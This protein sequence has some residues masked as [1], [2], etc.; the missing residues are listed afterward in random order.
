MTTNIPAICAVSSFRFTF[1]ACIGYVS[2]T[3]CKGNVHD[4]KLRSEGRA[5]ST[6]NMVVKKVLSV[7]FE[8][9]RKMGY[10]PTNPVAAVDLLKVKT[11][12]AR[13]GASLSPLTRFPR[14]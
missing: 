14:L 5:V 3:T 10:L 7:P 2:P 12:T 4:D 11:E 8:A 1:M 13:A 6:C 9:A